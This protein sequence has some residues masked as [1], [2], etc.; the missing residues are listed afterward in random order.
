M[1]QIETGLRSP[2]QRHDCVFLWLYTKGGQPY[3]KYL[4]KGENETMPMVLVLLRWDGTF[5]TMGGKVDEGESLQQAL[6]RESFEEAH[7][8]IPADAEP[9]CLGTFVDGP[10]HIHSFCLELPF[11]DLLQVRA[12]GSQM[13]NVS[14][15]VSGFVVAPAGHYLAGAAPRGVAAFKENQFCSTA[16]LEFELLLKKIAEA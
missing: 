3:S 5:G 10:W 1:K 2:D 7:Y 9:E 6:A 14:P 15:E 11:Q 13:E 12:V 4:P 8:R 16:K